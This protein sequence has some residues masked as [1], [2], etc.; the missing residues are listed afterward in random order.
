V[1][2]HRHHHTLSDE[3]ICR[4][5]DAIAAAMHELEA[6]Y[7][8]N[9]LNGEQLRLPFTKAQPR[10]LDDKGG[11][12]LAYAVYNPNNF[13][14]YLGLAGANAAADGFVVPK[15]KLLV[16]PATINGSVELLADEKEIGEAVGEKGTVWRWR[17]PTPQPFYVGAL[18]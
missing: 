11:N 7:A 6:A 5:L 10:Q 8:R 13:R 3:E 16:V 1:S 4:R 12:A 17:F 18:A 2:D 15:Q 9:F 14:V